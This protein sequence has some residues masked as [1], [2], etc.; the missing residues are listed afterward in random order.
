MQHLDQSSNALQPAPHSESEIQQNA[1]VAL[2]SESGGT[3][4]TEKGENVL[5][6]ATT[7][8]INLM[9]YQIKK[10]V[11]SVIVGFKVQELY[12]EDAAAK[13]RCLKIQMENEAL[14][15]EKDCHL[16]SHSELALR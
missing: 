9:K 15:Q 16:K 3:D 7:E 6:T 10:S 11:E 2:P 12:Q 13:M 14:S 4:V 1:A 8:A 5:K